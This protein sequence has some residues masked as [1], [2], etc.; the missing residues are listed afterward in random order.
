MPLVCCDL[1]TC[2]KATPTSKQ[3][4]QPSQGED[5]NKQQLAWRRWACA[6]DASKTVYAC[7][8]C[9]T[10]CTSAILAIKCAA[11]SSR[12]H[13][14][15][16]QADRSIRQPIAL[17]KKGLCAPDRYAFTYPLISDDTQK[18][19]KDT[20]TCIALPIHVTIWLLWYVHVAE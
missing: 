12:L 16:F 19:Q 6:A 4:S 13:G 17:E 11:C 7:L 20:E 2:N 5:S 10:H 8:I 9:S 14:C 1:C 3:A 18:L 15:S